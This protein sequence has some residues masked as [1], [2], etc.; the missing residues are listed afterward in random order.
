MKPANTM[1]LF[2]LSFLECFS[3]KP[4]QP[5]IGFHI[6]TSFLICFANQMTGFL[7]EMQHSIEMG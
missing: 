7:Y 4:F 2:S 1:L 6:E 5:K 3:F